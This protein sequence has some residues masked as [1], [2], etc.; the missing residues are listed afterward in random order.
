MVSRPSYLYYGNPSTWKRSLYRNGVL[1]PSTTITQLAQ[2]HHRTSRSHELIY[3][4]NHDNR[5]HLKS[6]PSPSQHRPILGIG[7]QGSFLI[8]IHRLTSKGITIIKIRRSWD[9]LIFITGI[10][11]LLR[12]HLY[13][14][15]G[16][17]CQRL[18]NTIHPS[19]W[20]HMSKLVTRTMS[21][22]A[23]RHSWT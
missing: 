3:S 18:R 13:I 20:L 1:M 16:P 6:G 23:H 7:T 8:W 11:I 14:E 19:L 17:S 15:T 21:S 22:Q 4:H 5:P 9:S 2:F 12:L 10:P